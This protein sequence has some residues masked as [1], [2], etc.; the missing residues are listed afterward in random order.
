MFLSRDSLP[1]TPGE[2]HLAVAVAAFVARVSHGGVDIGEGGGNGG[3]H[4]DVER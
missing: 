3:E 2:V 1:L 4:D